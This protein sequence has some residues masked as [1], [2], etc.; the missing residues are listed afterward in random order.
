MQRNEIQLMEFTSIDNTKLM[1]DTLIEVGVINPNNSD[2]FKTTFENNMKY[3]WLQEKDKTF[4]LLELDKKYIAETIHLLKNPQHK[5]IVIEEEI[6]IPITYEELQNE[7]RNKFELELEI[8]Q[9]EFNNA[10]LVPVPPIPN[11]KDDNN[12]FNTPLLFSE[13][14][15]EI[16]IMKEQRKYDLE[17]VKYNKEAYN[18]LQNYN[19][20]NKDKDK[21]KHVTWDVDVSGSTPKRSEYNYLI[22]E[23]SALKN[24]ISILEERIKEINWEPK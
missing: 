2:N 16:Q 15:K 21:H 1:W 12:N 8:K 22:E 20:L 17:N 9:K 14:N 19:K 13:I 23:I 18:E 11:F 4:S 5:K 7:K 3:F 24:R 10:L 6:K